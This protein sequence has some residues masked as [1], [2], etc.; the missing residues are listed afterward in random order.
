M[1]ETHQRLS[2]AELLELKRWNTPTIYNGW[3]RITR[4]NPGA[5]GINPE[6]CRDFMPQMGPMV[7][8]AVTLVI[9]PGNPEHRRRNPQAWSEY[10][11]Y[12]AS[13]PG[14]KIV[15]IQD[16]DK[17]RVIGSFWGEVN[18]NT[19]RALGCVGTITDGAIRDLDEMTNAG[20][21]A[22]AR[23][24][25][26]AIRREDLGRW[27]TNATRMA[28]IA[29]DAGLRAEVTPLDDAVRLV[30]AARPDDPWAVVRLFHL[31]HADS[32]S[33]A[34]RRLRLAAAQGRAL[35]VWGFDTELWGD[36]QWFGR[37]R[38]SPELRRRVPR[39]RPVAEAMRDALRTPSAW[40]LKP[41][42]GLCGEGVCAGAEASPRLW[43]DKL[44]RAASEAGWIL[45]AFVEPRPVSLPYVHLSSRRTV[46]VRSVETLGVFLV[47][48]RF[49]GA[50]ARSKPAGG[51]TIIDGASSFNAV[52]AAG[53]T[54]DQDPRRPWVAVSSRRIRQ[55]LRSF[56][57]LAVDHLVHHGGGRNSAGP[58]EARRG[59]TRPRLPERGV[60]IRTIRRDLERS[61]LPYCH[62]KR[63]PTYF[64]HMDVPPAD[65]SIA[66]GLLIRSLAQDP[67]TWTSS[68]AGTFVEQEVVRWFADLVFPAQPLS[69]GIACGGGTQA[70]LLAVLI[71]R[72]LALASTGGP[73]DR[74]GLAEALRRSGARSLKVFAS[75]AAHGSVRQAVRHAGL[76]DENLVLL[77]VDRGDSI[78]LDALENALE[79]VV[80]SQDR[81]ALVVLAAGSVGAGAIDDLPRAIAI[82]RAHGA[83]VHVD[84]A[85]GAMLL[86]SRRYAHRL[87]GLEKADSVTADPHKILGLNQGLG[88]LLVRGGT[89]RAAVAREPSPYFECAPGAPDSARYALD[90]TRP[91]NAL[92]AWILL[93]HLGRAG[94]ERVVD[95]LLSLS[96]LFAE[97]LAAD[98]RFESYATPAM[99]LVCFRPSG[100]DEGALARVLTEAARSCYRVGSYSSPRGIFLRAVFVNPAATREHVEGLY[101]SLCRWI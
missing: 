90:G 44:A 28:E 94:Y 82:A 13:V 3:E 33:E 7:G 27:G 85:H 75:V 72:N 49:A 53:A 9:E 41:H 99:N 74:I 37:V 67:V 48:G 25:C 8:Y 55:R 40:V 81:V 71:A 87:D 88:M 70:N 69:N 39:T 30:E 2:H 10:R 38:L 16:L 6:E 78:R 50:Y 92:G 76:G 21:K 31:G 57:T 47:A 51:G 34:I 22:I 11:R 36:K 46:W 86:F 24:L 73:V 89:D 101:R 26:V 18:S 42:A 43:R 66:A 58:E 59:F 80:R 15:V 97:R 19:H 61:L 29:R 65:L 45:Q 91:L 95:H 4:H 1:N 100:S 79:A 5:E 98:R 60:S 68:R 52:A 20:F 64:A 54:E 56:E 35:F 96:E 84:A 17:P 63:A 62:D 83:R 23:R 32:E 93:R 14:P 12:V 77:P